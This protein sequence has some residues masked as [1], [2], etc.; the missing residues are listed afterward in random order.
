MLADLAMLHPDKRP[1][2]RAQAYE[3]VYLLDHRQAAAARER[4]PLH[5][6]RRGEGSAPAD[7]QVGEPD[8]PASRRKGSRT[9][10]RVGDRAERAPLHRLDAGSASRGRSLE[11]Q[12]KR[13]P[14]KVDATMEALLQGGLAVLGMTL[15][16]IGVGASLRLRAVGRPEG[17]PDPR[18]VHR[19][20]AEQRAVAHRRVLLAR[21]GSPPTSR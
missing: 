13:R 12:L 9:S 10:R 5:G 20:Q 3:G 7:A 17:V 14:E 18:E 2:I 4:A 6:G 16:A 8:D 1:D 15:R 11:Q 19:G 21:R